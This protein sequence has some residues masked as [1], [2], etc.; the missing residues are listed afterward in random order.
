MHTGRKLLYL[1]A[2]LIISV[3]LAETAF[4]FS[5]ADMKKLN[6]SKVCPD[7]DLSGADLSNLDLSFANLS[8][9]ILLKADLTGANLTDA[10][11]SG[12]NLTDAKLSRAKLS[13]ADL[14]KAYWVNGKKCKDGSVGTCKPWRR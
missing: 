12:A 2:V 5:P 1:T 8:G 13:G 7:C 9:A 6:T 10:D 3:F 14:R 4:S 11:L